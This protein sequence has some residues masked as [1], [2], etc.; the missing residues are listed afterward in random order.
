VAEKVTSGRWW[1]KNKI[2]FEALGI[3]LMVVVFVIGFGSPE[4]SC[5]IIII[6]QV[7]YVLYIF[8]VVPWIKIRYKIFNVLGNV[9]FVAILG[10]LLGQISA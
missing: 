8:L 3:V 7:S 9:V 6:V 4:V 10:C 5:S 1:V 2:L